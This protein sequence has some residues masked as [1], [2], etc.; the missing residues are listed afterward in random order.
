VKPIFQQENVQD[1]HWCCIV[2]QEDRELLIYSFLGARFVPDAGDRP[3][4]T[5]NGDNPNAGPCPF[6]WLG[7]GS[8]V[9]LPTT[10]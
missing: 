9:K 7:A 1:I 2:V 8:D 6:P 3:T 4:G 5:A 10:T